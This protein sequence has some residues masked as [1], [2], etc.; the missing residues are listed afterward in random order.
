M[1]LSASLSRPL[2]VSSCSAFSLSFVGILYVQS[3]TRIGS[4]KAIDE[5]GRPLDRNHP[6]VIRARLWGVATSSLL[7]V[8]GVGAL[9]RYTGQLSSQVRF[10]GCTGL[11]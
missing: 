1:S 7:S 2:A 6:K 11:M 4:T 5:H 3:S 9:L 8:A 10:L